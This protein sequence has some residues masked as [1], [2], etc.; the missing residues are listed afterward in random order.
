MIRRGAPGQGDLDQPRV[1]LTVFSEFIL[2]NWH[3]S[4]DKGSITGTLTK[5]Y[6]DP[7]HQ[8]TNVKT[9]CTQ[10]LFQ[11][12]ESALRISNEYSFTCACAILAW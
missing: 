2:Q 8:T 1:Q 9:N 7:D 5:S 6:G 10:L 11:V 4:N 12:I 3:V